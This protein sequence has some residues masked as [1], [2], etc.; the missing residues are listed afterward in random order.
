[1]LTKRYMRTILYTFVVGSLLAGLLTA[2]APDSQSLISG[3]T[4]IFDRALA[5][6]NKTDYAGAAALLH[7]ASDAHSLQLLG[8]AYLMNN[9]LRKATETLERAIALDPTNAS[10]TDWLGRAWGRRAETAFP[11]AAISLATK[12]RDSFEKAVRLNSHNCEAVN[13]LFEFYMEAPAMLGGGLDKARTLVPVIENDNP[14]EGHFARAR[15]FEQE[16]EYGRAEGEYKRAIDAA[17]G[18]PGRLLDLAK[19]LAARGRID[20]SDRIFAAVE[21]T[22][23]GL[24]AL[25]YARAETLINTKRNPDVAA[26]LLRRYLA[27]PNLTPEDQP[28]AEAAKLLKK[29]SGN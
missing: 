25:L 26:D 15:I 8:Q 23:P 3:N 22:H 16:K 1:M 18:D 9:D 4:G 17:P 12:A 5:L 28:R 7:D 20:E 29:A 14:A 2:G 21:K 11:I 10:A 27:S 19:F 24:P 6:Y 13:D